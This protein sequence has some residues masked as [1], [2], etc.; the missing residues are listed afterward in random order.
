MKRWWWLPPCLVFCALLGYVVSGPYLA[1]RAIGQAIERQDTAALGRHVDFPALRANLKA[2]VDDYLVR[3]AGP[4][5]QSSLLGAF[6]LRAAGGVAGAGVDA[7]A[8]PAG[9]GALLQGRTLWKRATG[10]TVGGAT[11]GGDTYAAPRPD[12]PLARYEGRFDSISR[13]SATV[14]TEAGTPV[15]FVLGRDGLRWKLTNI[16]LPLPP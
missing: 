14:H 15:V 4:G 13:F 8:T 5:L 6:A 7:V 16:V 12:R 9:I 3:Q 2:Q 1:I 11:V 10:D